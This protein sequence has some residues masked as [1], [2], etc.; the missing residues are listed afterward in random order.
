[1]LKKK[2][3]KI[4]RPRESDKKLGGVL[5]G[6]ANFIGVDVTIARLIF[7]LGIL[8]TGDFGGV[9]FISYIIMCF[10]MPDYDIENDL[11]IKVESSDQ[12]IT[13][14]KKKAEAIKE[15]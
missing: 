5:A 13:T 3:T 15:Q 8:F 12:V 6:I 2:F 7:M 4:M 10:V 11:S 14:I 1:M 9:L